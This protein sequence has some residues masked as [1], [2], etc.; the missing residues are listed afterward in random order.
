[1][2]RHIDISGSEA[3]ISVCHDGRISEH[4]SVYYNHFICFATVAAGGEI[5]SIIEDNPPDMELSEQPGPSRAS[6]CYAY[7]LIGR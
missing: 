4:C 3:F 7:H 2:V 5:C 6:L 1:M